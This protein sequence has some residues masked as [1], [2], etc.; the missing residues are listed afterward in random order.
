M[1]TGIGQQNITQSIN[2]RNYLS[3]LQDVKL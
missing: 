2:L 3:K 1:Q